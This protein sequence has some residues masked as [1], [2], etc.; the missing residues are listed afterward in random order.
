MTAYDKTTPLTEI[1]ADLKESARTDGLRGVTS[2]TDNRT[3]SPTDGRDGVLNIDTGTGI[4]SGN[5]LST[6]A[7]S[8]ELT[9]TDELLTLVNR[10]VI[11]AYDNNKNS[12]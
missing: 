1:V 4:T 6:N 12:K 11:N 7:V 3:V 2:D 10:L 8:G 5:D 9:G